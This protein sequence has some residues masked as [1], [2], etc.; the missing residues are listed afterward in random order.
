MFEV[1]S[2]SFTSCREKI[3]NG[4]KKLT[5]RN[6]GSVG[7]GG[8]TRKLGSSLEERRSHPANGMG[9]GEQGD[10]ERALFLARE[11]LEAEIDIYLKQSELVNH[12]IQEGM[13]TNIRNFPRFKVNCYCYCCCY[14]YCYYFYSCSCFCSC[15]CS[16]SCSCYFVI[17]IVIILVIVIV[18]VLVL[19]L[20]SVIVI[21]IVITNFNYNFDSF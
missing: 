4:K 8:S 5:P 3:L 9:G 21:V 13:L 16:C 19:V 1:V 15:S 12:L 11:L 18:L 14:C 2:T 6:S 10:D 20:V 17:A 7:L